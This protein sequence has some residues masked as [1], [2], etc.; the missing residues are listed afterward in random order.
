MKSTRPSNVRVCQFRHFRMPP[1]QRQHIILYSKSKKCQHFFFIFIVFVLLN[2]KSFLCRGT[3]VQHYQ[4]LIMR[5]ILKNLYRIILYIVF[6]RSVAMKIRIGFFT[7]LLCTALIVLEPR[8][9]IAAFISIT[10]H[11]CGHILA[12]RISGIGISEV[13]MSIYG[14]RLSASDRIFSYKDEI[15]LCI[16]GPLVNFL[17]ALFLLPLYKATHSQFILDTT[18]CSLFLGTLNLMPIKSFDGGRILFSMLNILCPPRSAACIISAV[19]FF[20]TFVFW[21][22]SVYLLIVARAGLSAFV[23]SVS[24]FFNLFTNRF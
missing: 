4:L 13:K 2:K 22:L 10:L 6:L 14:A 17:L 12:A 23:F 5:H 8:I 24:L 20:V 15:F 3:L 7:I 9:A 11:E 16:M 1:H 21:C 18:V 19:S